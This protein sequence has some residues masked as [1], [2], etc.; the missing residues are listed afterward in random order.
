MVWCENHQPW[1]K[2]YF[3]YKIN[4]TFDR[5]WSYLE[6]CDQRIA[7]RY[8]RRNVNTILEVLGFRFQR[9]PYDHV[10]SEQQ[11]DRNAFENIAE[12]I[13]R[14]PERAGVV[15]ADAFAEYKF[16][17]CLTPGYPELSPW[18]PDYWDRFWRVYSRL[19]QKGLQ[20]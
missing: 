1:L 3:F 12:Y 13:A 15:S 11:R 17:G 4:F 16:T 7:A 10:L 19:C 6:A 5:P 8:F 18:Q 14:N 2:P 9:Q 20:V